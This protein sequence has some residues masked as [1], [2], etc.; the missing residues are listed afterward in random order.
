MVQY[1]TTLSFRMWMSIQQLLNDRKPAL[2]IMDNYKVQVTPAVT[3]LLEDHDVH[4]CL[5]PS[6]TTDFL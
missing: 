5:L 6:N 4:M 3:T 2:V 1:I